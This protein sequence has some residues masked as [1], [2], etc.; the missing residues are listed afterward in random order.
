MR[1]SNVELREM[2]SS[3]FCGVLRDI[4]ISQLAIWHCAVLH[5]FLFIYSQFSYI[6]YMV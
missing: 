6:M 2:D 1:K 5:N 3:E 4:D